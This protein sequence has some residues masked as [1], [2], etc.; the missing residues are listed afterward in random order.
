MVCHVNG[1]N[2]FLFHV[3]RLGVIKP[4]DSTTIIKRLCE[5]LHHGAKPFGI[6]KE[7]LFLSHW[8]GRMG[9]TKEEQK[10]IWNKAYGLPDESTPPEHELKPIQRR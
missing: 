5:E 2:V 10:H 6:S 1:S 8:R 3:S 9:F 4:E 7:P